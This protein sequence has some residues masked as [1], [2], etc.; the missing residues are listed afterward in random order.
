VGCAEVTSSRKQCLLVWKEYCN[1]KDDELNP[2]SGSGGLSVSAAE[3]RPAELRRSG[4]IRRHRSNRGLLSVGRLRRRRGWNWRV[5]ISRA[6]G[7]RRAWP[8]GGRPFAPTRGADRTLA[9]GTRP[10]FRQRLMM[11]LL[12]IEDHRQ[13]AGSSHPRATV[14]KGAGGWGEP[15]AG[16]VRRSW[17]ELASAS[18][19]RPKPSK[20]DGSESYGRHGN[21]GSGA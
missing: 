11:A 12:G 3:D 18:L 8:G 4:A 21:V 15:D 19:V 9:G 6:A 1:I 13:Q 5:A 14:C 16:C 2:S 17:Y 7:R 20:Q 10:Q